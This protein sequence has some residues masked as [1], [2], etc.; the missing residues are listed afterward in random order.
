LEF[1]KIHGII[2]N[3]YFIEVVRHPMD[4]LASM[5]EVKRKQDKPLHLREEVGRI[6]NHRTAG[7]MFQFSN[8]SSRNSIRINYEDV[9]SQPSVAAKFLCDFIGVE[10]DNRMLQTQSSTDG[11]LLVNHESVKGW[12]NKEKYDRAVDTKSVNRWKQDLN[13]FE[14]IFSLLQFKRHGLLH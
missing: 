7:K 8:G 2:P 12:Y 9:V 11:S 14:S 10:M 1:Q 13:L 4:V 3:A 5:K 6:I